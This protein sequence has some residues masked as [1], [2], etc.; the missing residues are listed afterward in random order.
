LLVPAAFAPHRASSSGSGDSQEAGI[1]FGVPECGERA[2]DN[3]EFVR[4]RVLVLVRGRVPFAEKYRRAVDAGAAALI[5][6]QTLDVYPFVMTDTVGELA[7]CDFTLPCYMMSKADGTL[8]ERLYKEAPTSTNLQLI[9]RE[10]V[11]ECSICCEEFQVGEPVL[12]LLCRHAYHASCVL[13]WFKNGKTS[14]PLC[15][16]DLDTGKDDRRTAAIQLDSHGHQAY[17]V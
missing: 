1:V 7:L 6:V 16:V 11:K 9:H 17:A 10:R 3:L 14:C 15:R 2:L 5:I 4:G 12:K 8:L 13:G